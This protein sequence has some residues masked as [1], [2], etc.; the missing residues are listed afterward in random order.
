MRELNALSSDDIRRAVT[1]IAHEIVEHNRGTQDWCSSACAPAACRWRTASATAIAGFE[2]EE[3]PVGSL[4]IGL[5]RDDLD[6]ARAGREHPA[7]ATCRRSPASASCW[8]TTCC[9]PAA[10]CARRSTR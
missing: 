6:R 9:S 8:S 2:G 7:A 5:Y 4:D 10:P 3:V 1:R